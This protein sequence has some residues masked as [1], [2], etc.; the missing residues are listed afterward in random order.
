MGKEMALPT[1]SFHLNVD[2][3]LYPIPYPP[4]SLWY[5][6]MFGFVW[7][8]PRFARFVP[9]ISKHVGKDEY[10]TLMERLAGETGVP[11]GKPVPTPLS[12]SLVRIWKKTSEH[13]SYAL[14]PCPCVWWPR[15]LNRCTGFSLGCDS[16][17]CP[18]WRTCTSAFVGRKEIWTLRWK[19]SMCVLLFPSKCVAKFLLRSHAHSACT[20]NSISD[21]NLLHLG[22]SPVCCHIFLRDLVKCAGILTKLYVLYWSWRRLCLLNSINAC[23]LECQ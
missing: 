8:F 1:Y 17:L 22:L 7:M 20:W 11:G 19:I 15:L 18:G 14:C 13:I 5:P 2:V 3:L 6:E 12:C 9:M 10:G 23:I 16:T 4:H 21:L